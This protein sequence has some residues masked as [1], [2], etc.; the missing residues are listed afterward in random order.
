M[1]MIGTVF[2]FMF[3]SLRLIFFLEM[4]IV[5]QKATRVVDERM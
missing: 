3:Y 1:E 4:Q 5:F 2:S